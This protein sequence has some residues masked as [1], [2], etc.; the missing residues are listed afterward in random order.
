LWLV[1]NGVPFDLA[2]ELDDDTRSAYAIVFSKFNG[3]KFDW[4]SFTFQE[5]G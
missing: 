1:F 5:Q 2:F 3:S 4:D